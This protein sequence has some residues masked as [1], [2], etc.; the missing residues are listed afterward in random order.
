[1][2]EHDENQELKVALL[3]ST[4][5]YGDLVYIKHSKACIHFTPDKSMAIDNYDMI[6]SG[7]TDSAGQFCAL[8]SVNHPNAIISQTTTEF[9]SPIKLGMTI[10]LTAKSSY[11]NLSRRNVKVIGTYSDMIV[12]ESS[13]EILL[14]DEHIFEAA[15]G[16]L[17][18]D[19]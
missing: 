18:F 15:I 3:L 4:N 8:A 10:V 9:L 13:V 19:I 7:F 2:N 17:D 16:K 14:L 6:H 5:Y 11:H 12:Y 1:M